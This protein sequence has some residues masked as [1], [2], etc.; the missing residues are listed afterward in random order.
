LTL[1]C[2][3]MNRTTFP[4]I[5]IISTLML[6]SCAH[7]PK[8]FWKESEGTGTP[9]VN[10][11]GEPAA[12]S[13]QTLV[14]PPSLR[15]QVSVPMPNKVA[16]VP[17]SPSQQASTKQES[18]VA[19]TAVGLHTRVYNQDAATVFSSV[20]D[21]MTSL[22]MPVQSVDS[23]SGTI[24]TDWVRKDASSPN[25]F[26]PVM[27]LFG[28]GTIMAERYRFVVRVLH[29]STPSGVKTQLEIR[30]IG[31]AFENHHWVDKPVKYKPSNDLF[32]AVDEQLAQRTRVSSDAAAPGTTTPAASAPAAPAP[33]AAAPAS[34][35]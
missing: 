11:N 34:T 16:S 8:L 9:Q 4:L 25:V 22:N 7:M 15:G 24:T 5:L 2:I 32:S 3:P 13:E 35:K 10:A 31:Q 28:E 20:I 23:P 1:E 30:T 12:P 21:A 14:V 26:T 33:S 18:E 17:P 19:G 27:N 6:A 29:L